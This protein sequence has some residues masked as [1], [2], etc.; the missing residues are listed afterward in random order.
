[1]LTDALANIEDY[2]ISHP[3]FMARTYLEMLSENETYRRIWK[4]L[5]SEIL[6]NTYR[7]YL[8]RPGARAL[9]WCYWKGNRGEVGWNPEKNAEDI[10]ADGKYVPV[11]LKPYCSPRSDAE[12]IRHCRTG[13]DLGMIASHFPRGKQVFYDVSFDIPEDTGEQGEYFVALRPHQRK[14]ILIGGSAERLYFLLCVIEARLSY[15][16][17]R[18]GLIEIGYVEG[19]MDKICLVLV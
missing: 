18:I 17:G 9:R 7:W 14:R 19:E 10:N 16:C 8:Y 2:R 4:L 6:D 5:R 3:F 1:M 12:I 13:H 15:Y 11:D